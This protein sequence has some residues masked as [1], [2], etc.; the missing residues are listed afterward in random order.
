MAGLRI[1]AIPYTDMKIA[2]DKV[3]VLVVDGMS[4]D[5]TRDIVTA[6]AACDPRVQ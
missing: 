6:M 5:D 4:E 2:L 3:E 1:V